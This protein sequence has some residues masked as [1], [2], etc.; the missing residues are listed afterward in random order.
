MRSAAVRGQS[1]AEDRA[2]SDVVGVGMSV[3]C[4]STVR[5]LYMYGG[6][7]TTVRTLA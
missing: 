1:D 6:Q 4:S 5:G 7:Y 3:R 2:S